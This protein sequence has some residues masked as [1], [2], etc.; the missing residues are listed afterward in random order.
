MAR[1][2]L[3][4]QQIATLAVRKPA[5]RLADVPSLVRDGLA[6]GVLSTRNLTEWLA[7]DRVQ[8]A[9]SVLPSILDRKQWNAIRREL[10]A[11]SN[12]SALKFSQWIGKK[13]STEVHPTSQAW[14]GM[15]SHNSDIIRE[16][17]ACVVGYRVDIPFAE[18]L[19]W[20]RP[21]AD[22]PNAGLREIAWMAL[23]N[24]VA[25]NPRDSVQ[26]LLAWTT[27][28]SERLRRFTSELTR[29]C[30]V[31]CAHI[32]VLKS[33][34]KIGLPILEPLRNDTSKY[35]R[36]SVANWLNDASKSNPDFVIKL[37]NRWHKESPTQNTEA[38]IKRALRTLRG[39][40]QK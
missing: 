12:L 39:P 33:H 25:S 32:P 5:L 29:P 20:I 36:D 11:E 17:A 15:A 3:T 7:V 1:K 34:P 38:I 10:A 13:L 6:T 40:A 30:G 27:E 31:W 37:T 28:T 22:D 2:S 19:S 9:Q 23:R 4:A 18:K 21:M 35:V 24:D 16:W 8:L 14:Q 26:E